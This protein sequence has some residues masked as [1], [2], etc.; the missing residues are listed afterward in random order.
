MLTDIS[1][2]GLYARTHCLKVGEERREPPRLVQ[3][4][5]SELELAGGECPCAYGTN[6]SDVG[7]EFLKLNL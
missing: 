5:G 2:S 4:L 7:G 3:E 6:P 1:E